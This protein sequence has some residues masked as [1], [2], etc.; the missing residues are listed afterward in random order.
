MVA[1]AIR[2]PAVITAP[3]MRNL[4]KYIMPA[5][6]LGFP[7]NIQISVSGGRSSAYQL[8]HIAEANF[9]IPNNCE[10]VFS[11]TSLEMPET[12]EFLDDLERFL[13]V[14][15]T[16]LERDMTAPNKVRVVGHNSLLRDGE[17]FAE[18]L[19]EI[20]P[21]RRDGTA[22]IRP[23]PNPAQRVCTANLKV[24]TVDRYL[25]KEL[26]W[27]RPY[28]SVIGYRADEEGRVQRRIRQNLK[29]PKDE[30]GYGIFPMF[31]A[32]VGSGDVHNFWR[33]M[34]FDLKIGSE[35]GN[36]D[37]CFMKSTWK[38]KMMMAL[39]PDRA[40]RWVGFEDRRVNSDRPGTFRQDRPPLRQLWNEVQAGD[41]SAP[42]NDKQCGVCGV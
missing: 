4:E 38:I 26:G 21:K 35:L 3:V 8:A 20:I 18:L 28:L 9:G 23:L 31:S 2:A 32:G 15:I 17:L 39:Y 37:F 30:G 12:Y 22:G 33:A 11:N 36:C 14:R 13:G 40:L 6:V 16:R 5:D 24:K 41:M 42:D 1:L 19:E 10:C 34:P 27:K 7:V 29:R 25:V